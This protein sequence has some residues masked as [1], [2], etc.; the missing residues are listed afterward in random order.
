MTSYLDDNYFKQLREAMRYEPPDTPLG[1]AVA[2]LREPFVLGEGDRFHYERFIVMFVAIRESLHE[3]DSTISPELPA[4]LRDPACIARLF[5]IPLEKF[6]YQGA[7]Q[8]PVDPEIERKVR[9]LSQLVDLL[10]AG[11]AHKPDE[12]LN[13]T[14]KNILEAIGDGTLKG[15]D[16]AP[17][18]GYEFD[19]H[20][21]AMLARLVKRGVLGNNRPGYYRR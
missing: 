11:V 2:R 15:E 10:N 4:F 8:A 19:S 13:D 20:F 12:E 1:K 7:S 5:G 16:I 6:N 21:K 18:A 3:I 17:I 9:E 14:E